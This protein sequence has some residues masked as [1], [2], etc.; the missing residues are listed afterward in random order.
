MLWAQY[1]LCIAKDSIQ[2]Q[3]PLRLPCY[4]FTPVEDT[5]VVFR[6]RQKQ[7]KEVARA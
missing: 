1:S 3:V 6:V 2:S 7:G 4:D 5:T